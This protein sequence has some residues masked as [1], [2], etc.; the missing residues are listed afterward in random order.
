[1]AD[2][3][4][5][6]ID[7]INY[8][9]FYPK[10]YKDSEDKKWPMILY[11]H[12]K[13]EN[14]KSSYISK[15]LEK[16]NN[17]PF[18]LVSPRCPEGFVWTQLQ[19]E[20]NNL[21]DNLLDRYPV[22]KERVYISGKGTGGSGTVFLSSIYPERFAG[23]VPVNCELDPIIVQ[24]LYD[25]PTWVF[26]SNK[27]MVPPSDEKQ[28]AEAKLGIFNLYSKFT[29]TNS[30][31]KR[32]DENVYTKDL[33]DWLLS[34][35]TKGLIAK[36]KSQKEITLML[37]NPYMLVG[38]KVCQVEPGNKGT[39]TLDVKGNLI[40]PADTLV[41][42]LGGNIEYIEKEKRM[43]IKFKSKNIDIWIG[44][45]KAKINNKE[46]AMETAAQ[47]IKGVRYI[48]LK[49]IVENSGNKFQYDDTKRKVLIFKEVKGK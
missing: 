27:A 4:I 34:F 10:G 47:S 3:R 8:D 43:T 22:D 41:K 48:P 28:K 49:F 15:G 14:T 36:D 17:S 25:V 5:Q 42:N 2:R 38:G 1:M 37:E 18:I 29:I 44:N 11:L 7:S 23:V 45:P 12:D 39:L 30:T 13:N 9:I 20:L 16:Y 6:E 32:I 46:K 33:F 19:S 26:N 40:V 21:L 35:N 24:N 31:G